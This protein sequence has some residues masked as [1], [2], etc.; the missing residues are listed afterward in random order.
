MASSQHSN[1]P[2][3]AVWL[4]I[5]VLFGV[6]VSAGAGVLARFGGASVESAILTAGGAFGASVTLI[7]LII[8]LLRT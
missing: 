2:L 7:V 3:M 4:A 5:G 6:L 1:D 8:K